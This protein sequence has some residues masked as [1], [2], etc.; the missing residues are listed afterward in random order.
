MFRLKVLCFCSPVVTSRF[1]SCLKTG[2]CF[3]KSII[4]VMMLF[5]GLQLLLL[6][7]SLDKG[8]ETRDFPVGWTTFWCNQ[9]IWRKTRNEML[10]DWECYATNSSCMR[11]TK[12]QFIK[13]HQVHL[14]VSTS[15]LERKSHWGVDKSRQV[16]R[17]CFSGFPSISKTIFWTN[18]IN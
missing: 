9:A 4:S 3:D 11:H 17:S 2:K 12:L 7:L 5:R 14:N 1:I 16:T 10:I 15:L 6:F 8:R 13:T 18:L